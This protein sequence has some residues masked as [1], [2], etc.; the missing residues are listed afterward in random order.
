MRKHFTS[1]QKKNIKNY[2]KNDPEGKINEWL[3]KINIMKELERRKIL[4][5]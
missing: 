1:D 4:G 3:D 5:L 2:N